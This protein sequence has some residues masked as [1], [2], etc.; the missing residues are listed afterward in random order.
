MAEMLYRREHKE[1][2]ED[3]EMPVALA[4]DLQI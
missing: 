1:G 2:A 3:A 4:T